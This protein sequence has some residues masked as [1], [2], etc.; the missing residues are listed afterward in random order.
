M[1]K[2]RHNMGKIGYQTIPVKEL[3]KARWNY[4]DDDEEQ[5]SKLINNMK[6]NGVIV[7]LIV[8][9]I[10]SGYEVV[11]GNH[12]LDALNELD[13]KDAMC[14]NLGAV[15]LNVAKRIAIETNETRFDTDQ[16][17]LAKLFSDIAKEFS[18]EE[19]AETMP[20]SE[21]ELKE[22]SEMLNFDWD[23]FK[24][25]KDVTFE[26]GVEVKYVIVLEKQNEIFENSLKK[27]C[28]QHKATIQYG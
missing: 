21:K 13:I 2:A 28:E 10:K 26:T 17:K 24:R 16:A 9:E 27:L 6:K 23:D 18:I 1:G 20:F 4:K 12:R 11:N 19:L 25:Q 8:R 3:R 14:Y 15:T 5:L 22:Y 7:N